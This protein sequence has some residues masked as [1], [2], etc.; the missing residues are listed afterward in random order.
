TARS[1]YARTESKLQSHPEIA[2][3][4]NDFLREYLDLGHME[5]V[6]EGEIPPYT[7]VYIPHHAVLRDSSAT[8][9]LRV[10]FNASC[11]TRDGTSLNDHLLIGPKFQ[12]DLPAI[13]ARWRQ[14][15]FVY[16]VDIAKMFRQIL[17]DPIDAD[18]QRLLW[19]PTPESP[20]QHFRLLTVT[21][22]LASAPYLAMRVIKQ[23]A[24]DDGP[25]FPAAVP[26][27]E[28]SLY[29]DDALFG[30]DEIKE[31]RAARD[32]LI[33]LMQRGGFQ[34]R[35]W[36]ANSPLLLED[37]PGNQ[38]ELA[39]HFIAADEALRVLGLSWQP[40]EDSFRFVTTQPVLTSP[41]RR[42]VLSFIAKLYDPLGWAAPVVIVA[43][44]LLQELWLLKGDWD[45]PIPQEFVQRWQ[46]YISDLPRLDCIRV[47]R[48]TGQHKD[49]L[50]FEVHGFADASNRAYAAVTYLRVVH[51]STNFQ[52]SLLSAKTKVAPVK[53]LSIPRL[54]L[55]AVVL[56]GR[57]LQWTKKSLGLSHVPI[58]GWTD[59]TIVLSWLKQHPSTW[60]TFVANRVSELQTSLPSISWNHVSSRENPADCAS[61]G[62]SAAELASHKLWWSGPPWLKRASTSWP[63]HNPVMDAT[64]AAQI[65]VEERKSNAHHVNG[66][67]EWELLHKYSSWTRLVRIT[68][69]VRR[70][71]ANLKGRTASL[72]TKKLPIDVAELR[73]AARFWVRLTQKIHFPKEWN[74]VSNN[75]PVSKSSSLNTLHPLMGTDS[76]LRLGGRLKNAALGYAERHPVLLP[77]NRVSELLIDQAHRATLHGGTQLT[78]R[79]LRQNYWILGGRGLVKRHIRQCVICTRYSARTSVQLMGDLPPPRVNPSPPFSHTGV[80]YAGPFGIISVVG[81]GQKPLKHYV[82]LFICLATKAIHLE[83][84]EDYSTAGF[85]A[86]FYRFVSRRGLPTHMYSDNGTNFHGADKELR[87]HF[88]SVC[89]DP[90]LKDALTNDEIQWHFI[91][92]AA[93]HFGGLWEAGVRS[94][95]FHLKR[96]IGSRTLS[97]TEFA[98]LLC[99]IEAC[100]NSRPIAALTDDPNDMSALTP[101]HFIIGRPLVA[102]P[103]ESVLDINANRL[104][105]WQLVRAMQEQ[106]WRSWSTDYLQSLQTRKKWSTPQSAVAVNDLVIVRNPLLPP[107]K[108]ELARVVQVHPG[109]DGYVRVVTVRTA[110]S[111]YKRP[112]AQICHLPVS[113]GS[114]ALELKTP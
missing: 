30:S 16:S 44:I 84:V 92:A 110:N 46:N 85:L 3:Q 87:R 63:K 5:P 36:A 31:L 113:S 13:I 9:K 109:S 97:K 22:G 1:L 52:V 43:K 6:K 42:S 56:L 33:G 61:R 106:I 10:V 107:S 75:I 27:V 74:A 57:L 72:P 2:T 45:D 69:Y 65:S 21:Y 79:T 114:D 67:L 24:M 98:T 78:L 90:A 95:K 28:H 68:A 11:K 18:F 48:W 23:L 86:A 102:V 54:E 53:T 14:W 60:T 19:R 83:T 104:S 101:G 58:Y 94:F 15:R 62:L 41:T 100:L 39:D 12:Q 64:N 70:F 93:P 76:L 82:A 17:I 111:Q 20:L 99:Q 66:E 81:R 73:E 35:K 40:H 34:L 91:P 37:I 105:R 38:H 80:D 29:V 88:R 26:I 7:P 103:E 50:W 108:W 89:A 47:P 8:T 96:V 77:K 59:S 4:Y 51:S 25:A 71:I 49:N 32:Q 112:I 55:S